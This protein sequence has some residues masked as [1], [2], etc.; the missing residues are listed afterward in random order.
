M[1]NRTDMLASMKAAIKVE[2]KTVKQVKHELKAIGRSD[3]A[4]IFDLDEEALNVFNLVVDYLDERGLIESVDS[5]TVTMLAKSLAVYMTMARA[6]QTQGDIVQQFE[7]GSSNVTGA[8]T[9]MNKAQ[10]QVMKLS[11]KLGLSPM[12]RT[13]IFGAATAAG[14]ATDKSQQGDDIDSLM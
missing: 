12:D 10:D 13:R 4:P 5:I 3:F 11:A 7:N 14:A 6:V 2:D 1:S 9:A 8:F